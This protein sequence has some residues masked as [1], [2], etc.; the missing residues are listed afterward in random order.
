MSDNNNKNNND[1]RGFNP[2]TCLI[3]GLCAGAG[4]GVLFDQVAIGVA[5]GAFVGV[6]VGYFMA[7]R[8]K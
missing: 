7:K 6:V 5:V 3:L 8:G 4:F 1:E 2:T